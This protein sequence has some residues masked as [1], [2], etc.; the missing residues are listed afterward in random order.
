MTVCKKANENIW[1]H[2][3][4][5]HRKQTASQTEEKKVGG[6]GTL[7]IL[8]VFIVILWEAPLRRL[9]GEMGG[10]RDEKRGK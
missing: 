10:N 1:K 4:V 6:T 3:F 2:C 9:Q 5:F 7:T 8:Y